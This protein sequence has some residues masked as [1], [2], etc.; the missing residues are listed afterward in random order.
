MV[1]VG[2]SSSVVV[3]VEPS[4]VVVTVEPPSSV[5][6]TFEPSSSVAVVVVVDIVY[7]AVEA[8]KSRGA[9]RAVHQRANG[10]AL[11]YGKLSIG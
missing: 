1:T 9:H 5:V 10:A 6:V 2:P 4:S 3:A 11:R 8:H 7:V